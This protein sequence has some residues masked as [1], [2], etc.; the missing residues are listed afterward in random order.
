MMPGSQQADG[1]RLVQKVRRRYPDL[2]IIVVTML[3]NPALVSSL[4]KLG[5]HGLV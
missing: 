3:G 5:I 4:L 1:L 2:P